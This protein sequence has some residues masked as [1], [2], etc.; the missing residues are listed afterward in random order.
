[1]VP[2]SLA[3][4]ALGSIA[5]GSVSAHQT[6]AMQTR[7]DVGLDFGKL[8]SS[9]ASSTSQAISDAESAGLAGLQGKMSAREVVEKLMAAEQQLQTALAIRDKTVAAIQEI[10]RMAI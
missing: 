7:A 4:N 8:V 9:T 5:G 2:F 1:M 10:S 6:S 3:L